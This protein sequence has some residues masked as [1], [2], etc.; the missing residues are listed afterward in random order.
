MLALGRPPRALGEILGRIGDREGKVPAFLST[1]PLTGERLM[2]LD[3][4]PRVPGEPL[5]TEGEWRALKDI[6]KAE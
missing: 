3:R 4:E 1:H 6:C 5:L 2:A